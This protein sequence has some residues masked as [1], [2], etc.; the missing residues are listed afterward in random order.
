[1]PTGRGVVVGLASIENSF[2]YAAAPGVG[3]C[4]ED[5]AA[6]AVAMEYLEALEGDFWVQVRHS[7]TPAAV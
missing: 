7:R 1:M 5:E 2:L 3:W 6:L 4:H